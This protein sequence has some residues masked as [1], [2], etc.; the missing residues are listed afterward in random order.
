[1]SES[2]FGDQCIHKPNAIK[3]NRSRRYCDEKTGLSPDARTSINQNDEKTR[4][5]LYHLKPL[6]RAPKKQIPPF[7]R[8]TALDVSSQSAPSPKTF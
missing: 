6:E 4:L 2:H 1:M 7:G 5:S 8:A 3:Y